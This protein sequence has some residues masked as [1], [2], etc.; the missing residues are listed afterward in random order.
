MYEKLE[1]YSVKYLP[2]AGF[3]VMGQWKDD[4]HDLRTRIVFDM[5]TFEIVEAEVEGCSV[6]FEI[7]HQGLNRIDRVVGYTVNPGLSKIV[8]REVMGPQGCYHLGEM[9]LN[10]VKS[11]LQAAS[12]QIPEGLDS[13]YYSQRWVEW[14][15]NYRNMCIY[16]AQPHLSQEDI[17]KAIG[18]K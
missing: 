8:S 17:Q 7:C 6:P 11:F 4:V 9:V 3:E 18:R 15:D 2:G 16:F 14:I 12:R 5:I 10:S 13:E 1:K